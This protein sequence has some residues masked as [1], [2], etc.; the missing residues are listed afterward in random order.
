MGSTILLVDD[1]KTI[2]TH[3]RTILQHAEDDYQ[4]VDKEDGYEALKWL[5]ITAAKSTAGSGDPRPKH[6]QHEWG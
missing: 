5:G 1:S 6:A 4:V 2:R 3:V